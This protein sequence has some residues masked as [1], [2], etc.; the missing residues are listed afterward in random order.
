MRTTQ[1]PFLFVPLQ[2][3]R[4][5]PAILH[6]LVMST[7]YPFLLQGFVFMHLDTHYELG[8]TP[9]C[10]WIE[11]LKLIEKLSSLP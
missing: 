9:L 6:S 1:S 8:Q 11:P 3:Y 4:C 7:T 5:E 2:S 10:L